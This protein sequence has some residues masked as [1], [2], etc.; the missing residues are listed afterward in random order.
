MDEQKITLNVVYNSQRMPIYQYDPSI[1]YNL[2]VKNYQDPSDSLIIDNSVYRMHVNHT[3]KYNIEVFAWDGANVLYNNIYKE[4]E[5][6]YEVWAKKPT[7]YAYTDSSVN[8]NNVYDGS[9]LYDASALFDFNSNP[10]LTGIFLFR[11]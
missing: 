11:G 1:Y 10:I 5:G 3:G 4:N 2:T 8:A 7:I 9:I 6:D